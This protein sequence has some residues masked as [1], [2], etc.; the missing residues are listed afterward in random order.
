MIDTV[1]FDMDGLLLDTEP[2]W[3]KSMFH[4]AQKHNIPVLPHQFKATTGLKIKEVVQYWEMHYPWEGESVD[5]ITNEIIE[6]II[7]LS[8]VEGRVMP[9]AIAL[10]DYLNEQG[11]KIGLAT[12]SPTKMMQ[13]L[14]NHYGLSHYFHVMTSADEVPYGKPH[15]AVFLKCAEHLNANVLKTLVLEDSFNGIIAGKAARMKVIAIPD[16]HHIKDDRFLAADKII[17]SLEEFD[18]NADL[19]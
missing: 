13:A 4:I 3:G 11:Y 18:F 17:S 12:S 19:N 2:L 14:I 15:P 9:G 10:L 5:T 16:A 6:H 7:A 8:I 1:I